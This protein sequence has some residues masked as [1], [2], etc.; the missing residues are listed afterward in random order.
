MP[1]F[2]PNQ[3]TANVISIKIAIK[4]KLATGDVINATKKS[5]L[6]I[7]A[8]SNVAKATKYFVTQPPIIP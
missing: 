6:A 8:V 2:T 7:V 5:P 3:T 1:R 4:T